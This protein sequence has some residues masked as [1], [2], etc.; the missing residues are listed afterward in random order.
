MNDVTNPRPVDTRAPAAMSFH[1]MTLAEYTR[2][3][4][5]KRVPKHSIL[6]LPLEDYLPHALRRYGL[7]QLRAV[8]ALW[9]TSTARTKAEVIERIIR[10]KEFREALARETSVSLKAKT[11]PALI[12]MAREARLFYSAL[13]KSQI[14]VQL[15][16]WR[17]SERA[18]AERELARARH[19]LIV[20]RAAQA[21]KA[22]PELN[23]RRYSLTV[24]GGE[25]RLILSVSFSEALQRAPQAIAAARSLSPE[26]FAVWLQDHPTEANKSFPFPPGSLAFGGRRFWNAVRNADEQDDQM[27]LFHKQ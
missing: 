7:D 5:A 11:R 6:A 15:L 17:Q 20:R 26:Q 22:V 2:T 13:N 23:L 4:D 27:S 18:R 21:G 16:G 3:D 9:G 24:N 14:A 25:D 19:E 1:E 10:R 8:A 12:E